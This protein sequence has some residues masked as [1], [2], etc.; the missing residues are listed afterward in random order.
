MTYRIHREVMSNAVLPTRLIHTEDFC[1]VGL[2]P[3]IYI[4]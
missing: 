2:H 3:L 1:S 4:A